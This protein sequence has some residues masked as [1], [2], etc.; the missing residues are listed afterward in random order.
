MRSNRE[1]ILAAVELG[2]SNSK[3]EGL[4]SKIRLINHRGYGHHSAAALITMIYLCPRRHHRVAAALIR[5]EH[6]AHRGAATGPRS[7]AAIAGAGP[8]LPALPSRTGPEGAV[9]RQR[10][11]SGDP[12]ARRNPTDARAWPPRVRKPCLAKRVSHA[13]GRSIHPFTALAW[14]FHPAILIIG[15]G[16]RGVGVT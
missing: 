5:V 10:R 15:F 9:C 14:I 7:R 6:R 11:G 13:F 4:N 3:L 16:A 12:P 2:L 1:R 8:G